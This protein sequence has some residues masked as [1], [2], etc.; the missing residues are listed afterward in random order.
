MG[1]D[2][3]PST[4]ELTQFLVDGVLD[5]TDKWLI[6]HPQDMELFMR[7][8]SLTTSQGFTNNAAKIVSVVRE[9]GITAGNYRPCRKISPALQSQ[10]TDIDSLSFASKYHPVYMQNEAGTISVFPAPGASPNG[11]IVYYVNKDPVNGS[12]SSLVLGHDDIKYFPIDKV[13]LVALYA[14]IKS[15]EAAAASKAVAQDI[16]LQ[17]SYTNLANNLKAEYNAAFQGQ[18]QQQA[19]APA[20]R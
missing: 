13:Y 16:E 14:S 17:G 6:G 7:A 8:S 10:V 1:T 19:G 9:D 12:G 15:L 4:T 5:I 3:A 11:Y 2:P 18:Q 20:R